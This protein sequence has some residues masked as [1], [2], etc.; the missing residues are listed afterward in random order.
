MGPYPRCVNERL[1]IVGE[2]QFCHY[3]I[4]G[5]HGT[6]LVEVG[7]TA[8]AEMVARHLTDI[9]VNPDYLVVTHPHV[10]HIT[11]L[12][13]LKKAFPHSTVI[14]G[15]GAAAFLRH[16]SVVTSI[17]HDD[18]YISRILAYTN[19]P[20]PTIDDLSSAQV[21]G[22]GDRLDLGAVTLEFLDV[23]GHAPG[24]IAIYVPEMEALFPSDALGYYLP[25]A[26]FFPLYFTGF[27]F[28]M[29]S[30]RRLKA[31]R[32]KILGTTHRGYFEGSEI[33]DVFSQAEN[34]A[35]SLCRRIRS[36][37]RD[38]NTVAEELFQLYYC[39]EL[40]IYSPENIRECCRLLVR[41]SR[42]YKVEEENEESHLHSS[43]PHEGEDDSKSD[44]S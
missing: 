18:R 31:L 32:P 41:R 25:P 19:A 3:V 34:E 24:H 5:H 13:F 22:D 36:D 11:G 9:G 43:R 2:E 30:M 16:T 8:T 29:D 15:H 6:A 42:E 38:E 40:G 33:S 35:L 7:V 23:R 37:G 17:I 44:D 39:E 1:W 12:A 4:R 26:N 21:Q 28:F 10:D 20:S 14:C 27:S